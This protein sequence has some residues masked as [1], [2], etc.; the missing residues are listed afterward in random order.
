[1]M[2]KLIQKKQR[3][4]QIKRKKKTTTTRKPSI[5]KR[6]SY[7]NEHSRRGNQFTSLILLGD[8][9]PPRLTGLELSG[10]NL[11]QMP[12]FRAKGWLCPV[13]F[14][15]LWLEKEGWWSPENRVPGTTHFLEASLPTPKTQEVISGFQDIF[16]WKPKVLSPIPAEMEKVK[17]GFSLELTCQFNKHLLTLLLTHI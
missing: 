9:R 14:V 6:A 2:K 15:T 17:P 12:M 13:W 16:S 5:S 4:E 11:M 10:A 1:M 3:E 8:L 7:S